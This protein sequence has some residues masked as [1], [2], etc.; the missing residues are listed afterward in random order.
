M[1]KILDLEKLKYPIGKWVS[2]TT[3][4]NEDVRVW[5]EVISNFA[6]K[7]N[8]LISNLNE[9]QL[10]WK[11]RPEGWTI[12]QVVHHCADSH[13]NSFIRYKL[14][15]TEDSPTIKPYK[16]GDWANL[17]DTL[18]AH[19]S[20]SLKILN[21]LHN[22]WSVLLKSLSEEDLKREYVHPESRR[23]FS[24]AECTSLYSWH[25]DHHFK[26]VQQALEYEGKFN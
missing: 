3:V 24:L 2:P 18:D 25:C 7:M 4:R 15:L 22:R 1:E 16:E 8:D 26:H 12:K 11:Y 17:P 5:T 14:A 21:G 13:M 10:N 23:K 20:D 6:F 9:D 19:I